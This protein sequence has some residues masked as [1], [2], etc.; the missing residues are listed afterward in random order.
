M[1]Y[2]Y[3]LIGDFSFY[4]T[5]C[6]SDPQTEKDFGLC[7]DSD[8]GVDDTDTIDDCFDITSSATN[9]IDGRKCCLWHKNKNKKIT[10][11]ILKGSGNKPKDWILTGINTS[12]LNEDLTP[13]S[14]INDQYP[15]YFATPHFKLLIEL[16][17]IS[18]NFST[19]TILQ[20]SIELAVNAVRPVNTVFHGVGVIYKPDPVAMYVG[21][22]VRMRTCM[23]LISDG[24]YMRDTNV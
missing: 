20:K 23:T 18:M 21:A 24:T 4:Y 1:L 7:N 15:G 5:K 10:D 16:D 19:D 6:Y 9:T 2:S 8:D 17:K 14:V 3:G 13:V 12:S 11:I 22:Y